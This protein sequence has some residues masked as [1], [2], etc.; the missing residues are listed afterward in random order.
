MTL[1]KQRD[2]NV[3]RLGVVPL[4]ELPD[5]RAGAIDVEALGTEA[6]E[7]LGNVEAR[8]RRE[9]VEGNTV[10]PLDD[11]LL[12]ATKPM[13]IDQASARTRTAPRWEK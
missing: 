10:H 1:P 4:G 3:V 5:G 6:I 12:A 8:D 11:Q 9:H 13:P 7:E 2:E